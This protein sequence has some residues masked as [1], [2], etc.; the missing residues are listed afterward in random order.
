MSQQKKK[1]FGHNTT[2]SSETCCH[3]SFIVKQIIAVVAVG[4]PN[5]SHIYVAGLGWAYQPMVRV[6]EGDPTMVVSTAAM[7][8]GAAKG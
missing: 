4:L 6:A 8:G 1:N 3:G 5:F 2:P 7:G